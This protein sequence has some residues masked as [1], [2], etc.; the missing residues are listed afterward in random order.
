MS[1]A[2]TTTAWRTARYL[3]SM[4]ARLS[5]APTENALV[6]PDCWLVLSYERGA[7]GDDAPSASADAAMLPRN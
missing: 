6:T 2:A 4:D 5:A 1:F 3:M 7:N